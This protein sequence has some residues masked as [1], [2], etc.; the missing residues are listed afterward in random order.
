MT[1]TYNNAIWVLTWLAF[2]ILIWMMTG[3]TGGFISPAEVDEAKRICEPHGG[4]M[5]IGSDTTG[6]FGLVGSRA[7]FF[8][9][10]SSKFSEPSASK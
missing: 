8:C 6:G 5:V 1:K 2:A 10:D 7:Q 3:C 9:V 4:L